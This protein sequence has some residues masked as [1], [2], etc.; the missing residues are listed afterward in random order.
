MERSFTEARQMLIFRGIAEV[1]NRSFTLR[2]A[3]DG[4]LHRIVELLDVQAGWIFLYA[5]ATREFRLAADVNLPG[6]LAAA[7]KR[8]MTGDCRCNQLLRE[9]RL[10]EAVNLIQCARLEQVLPETPELHR[11]ASVP[12]IAQ[13]ET[14]G[15]LNLLLPHGRA[16]S[17]DELAMLESIGHELAVTIQRA[18]LFDAVRNQEHVRRELMQRLLVAQEEERRRIAQDFHDHSGQVVTAL[19]IQLDQLAA[20]VGSK[21]KQLAAGLR[22]VRGLADQFLDDLR[23]LIYDLRPPVLDDLG[24]VPAVRWYVDSYVRPAGLDVDLQVDDLGGRLPQ[25]LET[26]AFR[27]FQEAVTNVLRHARASRI[28]IRVSR[29][30]EWLIVMVRDNGVGFDPDGGPESQDRRTLGLHGMRERAQLVDGSVQILS[31]NGV[32]TTIL[33]RLPLPGLD[34]ATPAQ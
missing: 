12:L 16:F 23:K 33:A 15:I 7:G 29:K 2:E 32:G 14:V 1:L 8:R 9:G 34:S 13:D 28:E 24:L 11:H 17:E 31:A 26:V 19:I 22:R 5:Q 27:I 10:T 21:N 6:A 4:A 25:D 30:G 18:R 20:D 3:L